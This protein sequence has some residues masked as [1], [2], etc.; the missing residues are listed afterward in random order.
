MRKCRLRI[1][2]HICMYT[3]LSYINIFKYHEYSFS[4][5]YLEVSS[6]DFGTYIYMCRYTIY[7]GLINTRTKIDKYNDYSFR[8]PD[9]EVSSPDLDNIFMY[10]YMLLQILRLL[11]YSSVCGSVKCRPRIWVYTCICICYM[12][13]HVYIYV[14]SIHHL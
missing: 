14:I 12:C 2:V 4:N 3:Y 1:W 6:W 11:V 13:I 7:I 9:A 5:L 10:I 8:N